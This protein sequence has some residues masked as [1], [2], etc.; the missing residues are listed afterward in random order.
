MKGTEISFYESQ[1]ENAKDNIK[2]TSGK[3][4]I[5]ALLKLDNKNPWQVC[6]CEMTTNDGDIVTMSY[7]D[8]SKLMICV[9]DLTSQNEHLKQELD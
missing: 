2:E 1:S 8:Y 4:L 3:K 6:A 7:A 9:T 5:E